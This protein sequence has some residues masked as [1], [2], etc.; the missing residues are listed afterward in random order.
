MNTKRAIQTLAIAVTLAIMVGCQSASNQTDNSEPAQESTAA[1]GQAAQPGPLRHR[2]S[3]S[4]SGDTV[5]P[6]RTVTVP[7]GTSIHIRLSTELNTGLTAPGSAFSGTLAEPLEANGV[8]VA[9]LGSSVG[10]RVTNVVSSGRLKRPAE[11]SLILTSITPTGGQQVSISTQTWG[12]AG[13]SHKKRDIMMAGGGAG[14]GALIGA[15]AGGGKGAAIGG[16]AGAAGGTGVAYATG[17][18]EIALPA[19]TA[20][21]FRLTAPATFSVR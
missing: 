14:L 4:Q 18:K 6:P 2:R 10:G 15:V 13:K 12:V 7:A 17:K 3:S 1:S 19:E 20:M 11:I 16:L 9:P 8:T 5:A 21:T